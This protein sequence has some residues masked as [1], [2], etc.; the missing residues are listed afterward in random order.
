[1]EWPRKDA[2]SVKPKFWQENETGGISPSHLRLDSFA[3]FASFRG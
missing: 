1:M 2:K 3:L